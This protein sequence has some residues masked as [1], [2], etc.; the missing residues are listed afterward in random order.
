MP[1]QVLVS[2]ADRV[3][4]EAPQQ[5][6]FDR[7]SSPI[8]ELHV[9]DGF[10]HDTLG[11]QDRV[12]A[13]TLVRG[14]VERV[15][16]TPAVALGLLDAHQQGF[17]RTEFDRLS[18]PAAS[19]LAR[20]YWAMSRFWIRAGGHLSAGIKGGGPRASTQAVPWTTYTA[21]SARAPRCWAEP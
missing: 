10:L 18:R 16:A 6:F 21:T 1:T 20:A 5:R 2:G 15:F 3:V 17:T 12:R 9:F 13:V 19:V 11:E 7:L 14:F 8:K 4:Y